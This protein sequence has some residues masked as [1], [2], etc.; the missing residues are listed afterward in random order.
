MKILN[1]Q[2]KNF[3]IEFNKILDRSNNDVNSVKKIVQNILDDVKNNGDEAV[4]NHILK[5]DNWEVN[6][7]NK[8]EVSPFDMQ[9]AYEN[10]NNN[11]KKALELAYQRIEKYHKK[12]IPKSWMETEDNGDILGQKITPIDIA[13][14]YIPGG[15]A[16]YPSSL[17]MNAI[18]AIVAG[19]NEMIVCTPTPNGKISDLMLAT[20][21]ICK[22]KKAYKVGGATAIGAMAYGTDTI[23]KTDVITGPGNIYVAT[24]KKLVYGDVNIDMIA[25][26]SEIVIIADAKADEN[27]IAID[28]LSQAE[29]DEMAMSIFITDNKELAEKV[30]KKIYHFLNKLPKK[31]IASQSIKNRSAIII[32]KNIDESIELSNIIAPEHLEIMIDKAIDILPKIKNAGAIFLGNYTPEAIGDYI[33]GP[34]HTLPTGGTAR[35]YSP[36]S[37]HNFIKTSSIISM[38]KKGLKNVSK[39]VMLLAETEGLFAHKE[40]INIRLDS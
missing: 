10:L 33:A 4:K 6:S 30:E 27:F 29:H 3:K 21:H 15:K 39:E 17:L 36:L 2:D 38:N 12:L 11:L 28:L 16:T 8:L 9:E 20:L 37:V 14:F 1:N 32:T 7:S 40:S 18:P 13:G 19:V 22:I 26:P 34:N 24:A 5:F 31:D 35:F 23:Q 25:G